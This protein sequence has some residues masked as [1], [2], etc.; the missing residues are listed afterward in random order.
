MDSFTVVVINAKFVLDREVKSLFS[1]TLEMRMYL[2]VCMHA[3]VCSLGSWVQEEDDRGHL[4]SHV[5]LSGDTPRALLS[6][7]NKWRF[8]KLWPGA[9]LVA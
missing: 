9:G 8:N 2:C 6:V 1:S 3:Y 5:R 7:I 4:V